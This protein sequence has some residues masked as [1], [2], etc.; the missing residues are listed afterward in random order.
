MDKSRNIVII[1][2]I[3]VALFAHVWVF[4]PRGSGYGVQAIEPTRFYTEDGRELPLNE[5]MYIEIDIDDPMI[6]T[7]ESLC[8]VCE[9]CKECQKIRFQC[10]LNMDMNSMN[11][12]YMDDI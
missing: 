3:L 2:S 9:P 12:I 11:L 4:F 10:L 5:P 7:Q 8:G 6:I 1:A